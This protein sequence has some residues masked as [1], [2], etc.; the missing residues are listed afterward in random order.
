M[1]IVGPL[2][3]LLFW[4]TACSTNSQNQDA[5]SLVETQSGL[6]KQSAA[7][8]PDDLYAM[9]D[10]NADHECII[11]NGGCGSPLAISSK[12]REAAEPHLSNLYATVNCAAPSPAIDPPKAR[13]RDNIFQVAP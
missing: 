13:C 2:S 10:C 1:K 11:V 12:Y 9:N 3:L 5:S 4:A 8:V 6:A 7:H